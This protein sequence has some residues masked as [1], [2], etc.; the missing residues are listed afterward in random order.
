[1][2]RNREGAPR[3]TRSVLVI[4]GLNGHPGLLMEA[5]PLLLPDFQALPFNHHLDEADGGVEGLAAR[6][7]Q[8]V[9]EQEPPLGRV[10]LCGESFGGTVALTMAHLQPQRVAGLILFSTFGWHPS[11]LARR[12]A[13]ALAVWSFLGR[14]VGNSAYRAGRVASVPTQL[15]LR[16]S[17]DLF[18]SYV[19]RPRAHLAAYRAKAELSLAFD[20]RPW[21]SSVSC[22]TFVLVGT[23]DPVVPLSAG[24]ELAE[25]IPG[26]SLHIVRGGHL[27]HLVQARRVGELIS[28][29]ARDLH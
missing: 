22:P 8:L 7:L 27:V 2:Q 9:D 11:T 5:A 1:V 17:T 19:S 25:R 18:R 24:R 23:W 16:F 20:A 28:N 26:A 6:A 21:L 14:R 15:G 29:W 10:V 4:P 12:G 3:F 13:G